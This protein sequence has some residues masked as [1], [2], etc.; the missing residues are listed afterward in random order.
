MPRTEV[1]FYREVSGDVP[2]LDWLR[3]L[4]RTDRRGY[5]KCVARVQRLAE[6]G[7]ELRRP[8]ADFLR[9]GI[10]ELRARRGRVHYRILYFFHGNAIAVLAGGLSKE[11]KVP[12]RDIER[13]VR[14]KMAFDK[15][16]DLENLL[17]DGFFKAAIEKAQPSWRRVVAAAVNLGLPIPGFS[18]ALSYYDGYRRERLPANLLQAQRDYFGAHTYQRVD[19]D[20]TFHTDWLRE[21]KLET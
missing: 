15:N 21:R 5:A 8:E 1:L 19:Q 6:M 18:A 7:H 4:R 16:P 3:A 12:D 10:H 17:L 13:A 2:V 9:E 11:G 14:R 20:G